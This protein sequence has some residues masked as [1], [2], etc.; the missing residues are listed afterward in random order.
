LIG[1]LLKEFGGFR[2]MRRQIC[3]QESVHQHDLDDAS[4]GKC[5]IPKLRAG[6]DG[7]HYVGFHARILHGLIYKCLLLK[8][9]VSPPTWEFLGYKT[10]R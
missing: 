2:I 6:P 8:N 1:N 5:C 3:Q 9:A 4:V 10:D 7:F